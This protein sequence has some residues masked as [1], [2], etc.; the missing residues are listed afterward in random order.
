M[1][2]LGWV[3]G[4]LKREKKEED[5]VTKELRAAQNDLRIAAEHASV[6]GYKILA[7]T[8]SN[9]SWFDNKV[10]TSINHLSESDDHLKAIE[11][12]ALGAKEFL[13]SYRIQTGR[14]KK[15]LSK[16]ETLLFNSCLGASKKIDEVIETLTKID[17]LEW[18]YNE[19]YNLQTVDAEFQF[20]KTSHSFEV[21][22]EFKKALHAL[23]ELIE[24][25]FRVYDLHN[26]KILAIE[27]SK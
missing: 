7:I 14:R 4:L 19:G 23:D 6:Y 12:F 17:E 26:K 15:A 13:Q 5:I 9:M 1:D 18:S 10:E 8:K 2:F 3:N 24:N 22:G 16:T 25:I 11:S 20:C 27:N 21:G